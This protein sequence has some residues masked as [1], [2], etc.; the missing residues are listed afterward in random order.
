MPEPAATAAPR[1]TLSVWDGAAFIV[2]IVVGIGIFKTPALVA[3][4]AGSETAFLGAW[5]LGGI[6]MLMGALCYAELGSAHPDAGGEYH[7]LSLAYGFPVGLLFGWA[8]GTVIQT[9]AIAAV[10]FVYGEYASVLVPLGTYGTAI[11]A[12]IAVVVITAINV[13]G[14]P[15]SRALQLILTLLTIAALVAVIAA[16]FTYPASGAAAARAATPGGSFGLAMVFV[17]LTYGGWNEAAYLAGEL[18]DPERN[19]VRCLLIGTC[20]VVVL[21]LLANV[22][23][24]NAFGL[25]DLSKTNPVGADLMRLAVGNA[26]AIVLS[27]IVCV[28]ALSTLNATVFTGARA[29]YALGRDLAAIRVLGVWDVH[30]HRPA[31]ALLLQAAIAL[32]LVAFGALARDGFEAMVRYTAPV[33]WF[34]L[35]LVALSVFVF[36]QRDSGALRYRMPLYPLPPIFLA[37]AAAWMLYSSIDYA[38]IG[39]VAGIVVLLAGTPL[40][41]LGR[42]TSS[43]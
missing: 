14:T 6:V 31:N 28:C 22:A 32:V 40:L 2:G 3:T 20:V 37:A 10:A 18:R 27:L 34:F 24:L 12:A 29:Y 7:Y 41:L 16:G 26:G 30:G 11:H 39:S 19:V 5:V 4:F 33:F 38:G 35:L 8:R 9:G 21:Y 13:A 36:R 42:A 23:Y 1:Q 17:L 15:Q 43:S 25:L